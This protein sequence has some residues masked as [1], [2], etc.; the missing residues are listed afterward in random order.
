VSPDY[1]LVDFHCHMV[2]GVDDGAPDLAAAL[3]HLAQFVE[4]GITR[5]VTTPHLATLDVVGARRDRIEERYAELKSAVAERIPLLSLGLS[6]EI[7]LDDPDDDLT[8]PRLGLEAGGHLLVE[9][10]ML[11]LPAYPDRMLDAPRSQGWSPV[12]AHPERYMGVEQGFVWVQKWRDAGTLMCLNAGSLWGEYG[13]E[14][15]RVSH[16]M[17]AEGLVDVIASDHH[18]RPTRATTVRD[19]WSLLT[20][21][22][23]E[24]QARTLCSANPLAVLRG[25]SCAPV[26]PCD[27]GTRWFGRLRR[28]FRTG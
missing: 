1:P 16:R 11:M 10:P 9:F 20:E 14:A 21:A 23:Y 12:L 28:L 8:D 7:R 2:P 18:A 3:R 17:L 4:L 24:E 22:G 27:I 5:V 19:A 15:K 26:A 13:P 6:Y 25:E